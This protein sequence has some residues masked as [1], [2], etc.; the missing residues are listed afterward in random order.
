MTPDIKN[1][2]FRIDRFQSCVQYID[3]AGE[4][5]PDAFFTSDKVKELY[6]NHI[7]A[8]T[9]HVNSLN[10]RAFK[11]EPTILAWGGVP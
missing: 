10:G 11:D 2:S 6:R 9:S 5:D 3:W 4:T 8:M 7:K 1:L